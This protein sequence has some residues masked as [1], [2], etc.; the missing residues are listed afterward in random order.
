M[1]KVKEV[2]FFPRQK[3]H[4]DYTNIIIIKQLDVNIVRSLHCM[5]NDDIVVI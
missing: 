4:H 2:G 1:N 5:K 3:S